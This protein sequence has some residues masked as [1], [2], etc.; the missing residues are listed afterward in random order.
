MPSA[1]DADRPTLAYQRTRHKG[2]F[3]S[4]HMAMTP[5]QLNARTATFEQM[6]AQHFG[7]LES[8]HGFRRGE[9]RLRDEN[10]PRDGEVSIRFKRADLEIDVGMTLYYDKVGV[11]LRDPNW[12][13]KPKPHVKWLSLDELLGEPTTPWTP[14]PLEEE[15]EN[16]SRRFRAVQDA[17]LAPNAE[18]FAQVAAAGSAGITRQL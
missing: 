5:D 11:V 10:E 6:V 13:R 2:L 15:F 12:H 9:S 1:T 17:A 14:T 7:W 16:L 4:L 18:V 3:V 8:A